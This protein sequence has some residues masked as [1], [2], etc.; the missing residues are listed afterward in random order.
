MIAALWSRVWG[1]VAAA[2][3][4][5]AAVAGVWLAGQRAGR[6]AVAAEAARRGEE[7]RR[8]GDDAAREAQREGA[9]ERLRRG[10]F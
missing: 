2:G 6:D 10:E 9:G 1:Y 7:A 5:V 4:V 3:A 8:R